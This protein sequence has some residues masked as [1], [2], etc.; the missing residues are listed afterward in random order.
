MMVESSGT[1]IDRAETAFEAAIY[2]GSLDS[3]ETAWQD[4]VRAAHEE[5]KET[6]DGP[7]ILKRMA[8][9]ADNAAALARA[10]R[11]EALANRFVGRALNC[12]DIAKI[13]F[14]SQEAASEVNVP[15]D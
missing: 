11:D 5:F 1:R 6:A 8:E 13:L 15:H 4:I 14:G 10:N 3:T 2:V 7:G 12:D 9:A